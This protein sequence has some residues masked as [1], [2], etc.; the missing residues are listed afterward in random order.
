M[1]LIDDFFMFHDYIF[2]SFKAFKITQS[3]TY[4]FYC[5][6][7]LWYTISFAK[8]IL[9]KTSYV[10]LGLAFVFLGTSI[11]ID[12]FWK[13]S[14]NLKYFI[15]DGFKFIGIFSWT[16]FFIMTSYKLLLKHLK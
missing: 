6:L 7:V 3:I 10:I 16:L 1:L 2:Y 11:C 12:F 9:N 14:T 13:N 15:E 8:L 5:L 4:T